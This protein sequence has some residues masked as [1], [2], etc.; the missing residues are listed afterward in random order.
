MT[1]KIETPEEYPKSGNMQLFLV[2]PRVGKTRVICLRKGMLFSTLF[3]FPLISA[4]FFLGAQ[5]G[6]RSAQHGVDLHS[7]LQSA[8]YVELT[9]EPQV[10]NQID[11]LAL[12][13]G[14]LQSQML[15]LNVIGQRVIEELDIATDEFD[16]S[17]VPAMGGGSIDPFAKSQSYEDLAKQVETFSLRLYDQELQLQTFSDLLTERELERETIPGGLPVRKGWLTSSFGWRTDPFTGKRTFHSGVDFA[18]KRGAEVVAVASGLVI[19]A[20]RDGGYGNLVAIDHGD[21]YVTRYAHNK[22]ILVAAGDRVGKGDT[23][24]HMGSTGHSTGTHVHFEVLRNGKKINPEQFI[25]EA[26]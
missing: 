13:L 25:H 17:Q 5:Y 15:R 26:S 2:H 21:G 24:A 19:W 22:D 10:E 11:A 20:S 7:G 1:R 4:V 6:S 23:I 18:A 12:R 14:Q 8:S 9:L 3:F 16:L